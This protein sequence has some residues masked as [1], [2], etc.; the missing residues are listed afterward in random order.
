MRPI[1]LEMTAF[2]SYAE[3]TTIPF[4]EFDRG[5]FLIAGE[6]GAGKTM[7]FDAI[8]FAL[9]GCASGSDR[10]VL[11]MHCDR[12]SL[13]VDTVVKLVFSQDEREYTVT[14]S[15]HFSKKRGTS[16]Q[17]GSGSQD[18]DL[19]E[20]D[21]ITV[22]GQEKVTARCAE[23]L[24]MNAEQFRKIV[25]LAQGEFREFLKA[26]SDKKNEI[27]G[28]LFDNSSFVRYRDLLAGA[29]DMLR[30]RRRDT[31]GKLQDLIAAGFPEGTFSPEERL[32]YLPENPACLD[33]LRALTDGDRE[34]LA[35]SEQ[36]R[37]A[38][39]D[40][41]N[42]LMGSRGAAEGVNADLDDL[43]KLKKRLEELAAGE[44]AVRA[45]ESSVGTVDTVLH[46]VKPKIDARSGALDALRNAEAEAERLKASLGEKE[47]A[48]EAAKAVTLGDAD[49]KE[50]VT[51]LYNKILSLREQLP[52]YEELDQAVRD[53]AAAE[54]AE[55]AA[56][57]KKEAD[58]L[59][60][61]ALDTG[62]KA[63]AEQLGELK[64]ADHAAETRTAEEESAARAL[65]TFTGRGGIR[66]TVLSIRKEE[67]ALE[68]ERSALLALNARAADAA[69][70]HNDL[71][72]KFIR[73]QAGLLAD[74]LRQQISEN[75]R[76]RCPV[77]GA[78]HEAADEEHFAAR[79]E[80]TPDEERVRKAERNFKQA[81]EARKKQ[82]ERVQS[83][84][85]GLD[86]RKHALMRKADPLFP[87]CTWEQL[88]S[89]AFLTAADK[90]LAEKLDTARAAL[91][92]A[93]DQ[94]KLRDDLV[95]KQAADQETL[96]GLRKSVEALDG[97]ERRCH[98][99]A[100]KQN[101]AIE[102]LR[103]ALTFTSYEEALE[104]SD[105]WAKERAAAQAEIEAHAQAET[106]ARQLRD[107]VKGRLDG[108]EKEIPERAEALGEADR[109]M[110][111][112]LKAHGFIDA[113]AALREL[114]ILEGADG[115]AWLRANNKA[116]IDHDKD[117]VNTRDRIAD[118]ERKT[119][120]KTYTDLEAL[121]ARI[122]AMEAEQKEADA[123]YVSATGT[124]ERHLDI[125]KKAREYKAVLAGT[126]TAWKRLNDLADLAV[127]SAGE[128]GKLSFDRYVMGAVFREILDMANQ[129]L[130]I[131]S[132]GRYELVHKQEADRKNARAG[133]EIEVR[134]NNVPD[135]KARPSSLLSG[136]EGFY[137]SL[138]LALG[139]SDVVQMHAGGKKLDALFIDEGFGT[140]SPDVLD[141]ALEVLGQLS[142]GDRLVGII[143]HVDKLEES[144]PQKIRV[145]F[146]EKGSHARPELS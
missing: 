140:L 86:D 54:T 43:N 95:K 17:Y 5:L 3:K 87:G 133:L 52:R 59:K 102:T 4:R 33:N 13:S 122:T 103:K 31:A 83:L 42:A 111:T 53:K 2:G 113:D 49:K 34:A 19:K 44:T 94:K 63:V 82:D 14:R 72:Q 124:L 131:M 23:I 144:I 45:L 100:L 62:L 41:L 18:A 114:D 71:Y 88:S 22:K 112:A 123:A 104:R 132:G 77:C 130:N 92:K 65:E 25:M 85:K 79:S 129:R 99:E 93:N 35:R 48:L 15:I 128:G 30:S 139:L 118:L 10:E 143:S 40:R 91:K 67:E 56:R 7:I 39:R 137:A 20:P 70:A 46:R 38:V 80:D 9:Y 101:T 97:E 6:T 55:K 119:A 12:V 141:K 16:D 116:V 121:Q 89:E 61:Q 84:T 36:R 37:K 98:D 68:G 76:A 74:T 32:P 75:G 115:E 69:A 11:R 81:D 142:G 134:D 51:L 108:K 50:L 120:G 58:E 1:L 66:E 73:G 127:G 126:D 125:L 78:V 26:D 90:D 28:R 27:L 135:H 29:R 47:S 117:T 21:G 109:E 64:D 96:E 145:T 57:L 110:D 106:A 8:V 146:D 138:S 136:G 107:T 105:A 60:R 24:G